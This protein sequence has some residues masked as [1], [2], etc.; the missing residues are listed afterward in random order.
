MPISAGNIRPAV[1]N[2][3]AGDAAPAHGS[4]GLY[5]HKR[6]LA[7]MNWPLFKAGRGSTFSRMG[8]HGIGL[9]RSGHV[10]KNGPGKGIYRKIIAF[11]H[12]ILQTDSWG[13]HGARTPL[14]PMY[15]AFLMVNTTLP[16]RHIM[17]PKRIIHHQQ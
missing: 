12:G 16:Y 9:L 7:W 13:R 6:Y 10:P 5:P 3:N 4:Y 1:T 2:T 15:C 17:N 11:L 8:K 14:A